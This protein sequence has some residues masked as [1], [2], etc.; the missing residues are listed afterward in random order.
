[1]PC[2]F[3]IPYPRRKPFSEVHTAALDAYKAE[4]FSP[5]ILL[6]NFMGYPRQDPLDIFFIKQ[7]FN[8]CRH[9]KSLPLVPGKG[10][11]KFEMY[12]TKTPFS[13]TGLSLKASI[14]NHKSPK[15]SKTSYHGYNKKW[16]LSGKPEIRF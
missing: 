5:L 2:M 4:F 8:H 13:L 11:S 1:Y 3:Y 10:L 6:D 14:F 9:K 7:L 16:I 12:V 15:L